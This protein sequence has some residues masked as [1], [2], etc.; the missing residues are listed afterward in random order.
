MFWYSTWDKDPNLF[1]ETEE[2]IKGSDPIG[3]GCE[4]FLIRP[5]YKEAE[6]FAPSTCGAERMNR[7]LL[8]IDTPDTGLFLFYQS[9]R[10]LGVFP[11]GN[12]SS[13]SH[14]LA[15]PRTQTYDCRPVTP[16]FSTKGCE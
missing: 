15:A 2:V 3:F 1:D 4:K 5:E 16:C 7:A 6:E 8:I 14:S 12:P 9:S 11:Q 10:D 13:C